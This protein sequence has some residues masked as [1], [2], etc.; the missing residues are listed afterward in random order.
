[1][2]QTI[3]E[4]DLLKIF[5]RNQ[6]K[7][8]WLHRFFAFLYKLLI[9][10]ISVAAVYAIINYEALG[11]KFNFWYKT[12]F[13]TT[14]TEVTQPPA[15]GVPTTESQK[16]NVPTLE[17]N[18]IAVPVIDV[19]APITFGV[20]NV[21]K[22]V[23]AGLENG[24]IQ[25]NGTSLPGQKGNV[26]ITGHSSNY[27]WAKGNYNSVFALLDKLVVGDMI[28]IKRNDITYEYKVYEQKIVS[29]KD[30][31]VL[32]STEDSRLTLVTCWPVGTALKRVVVLAKQVYPDPTA[33]T[34]GG[35]SA[36]LQDL[37]SGL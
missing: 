7:Q 31:S 14:S 15:P 19:S 12:D 30:T 28:Y 26:Y 33:N 4:D 29:P 20:N 24:A 22:E 3:S 9:G 21:A 8:D 2:N 25:I 36:N 16:R 18:W 34:D 35:N 6:K 37:T 5:L 17:N 27:V 10:L 23:A 13:S 32:Q 1:M 11:N